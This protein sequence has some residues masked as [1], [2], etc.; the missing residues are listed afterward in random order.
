H[1]P[2][3]RP[4][5]ERRCDRDLRRKFQRTG[6]Q[7]AG[8]DEMV[9]QPH[10]IGPGTVD[11]PARV[12]QIGRGLM[13]YH[14][15]QRRADPKPLVE[16]QQSEVGP[17]SRFGSRDAKVGGERETKAAA[18]GRSL[19][20]GDQRERLLKKADNDVVEMRGT[21]TSH[22]ALGAREVSSGAEVLPLAAKD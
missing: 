4:S 7:V 22:R 11:T 6:A 8:L 13:T 12:Q 19:H 3:N 20:G 17:E 18:D 10:A 14:E 15:W 5:G 2:T 21:L 1:R 16:A 9:A